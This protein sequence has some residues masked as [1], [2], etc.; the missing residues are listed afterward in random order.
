MARTPDYHRAALLASALLS[1][2]KDL[3][4]WRRGSIVSRV[5]VFESN[6]LEYLQSGLPFSA[7]TSNLSGEICGDGV[8]D[9]VADTVEQW[10]DRGVFVVRP[11]DHFRAETQVSE[12]APVL[13]AKGDQ[14]L[15]RSPIAAILNSR[16]PRRISPDHRWVQ[17]TLAEVKLVG[18]RDCAIAT[19]Y[20][21]GPY[22]LISVAA[23]RLACPVIVVCPEVLPF[24]VSNEKRTEFETTY[25]ELFASN[26]SLF[27]SPFSPGSMP[28][29]GVRLV[30]RDRV[31]AALA[32]YLLIAEIRAGGTMT[33]V[34]RAVH[35]GKERFTVFLPDAP[36]EG[37]S[38]NFRAREMLSSVKVEVLSDESVRK[39]RNEARADPRAM[40]AL[41]KKGELILSPVGEAGYL[42]HYTRSCPGPWPG[43]SLSDYYES[44]IDNG[45]G[46][47][48][49]AFDTLRR[50]LS[51]G[52]LRGSSTFVRGKTPVVSFTERTPYEI[53]ELV[54]WRRGLIRWSFE[55]YGIAIDRPTLVNLG[56]E[57]VAYGDEEV[58]KQMPTD[59]GYLF[60]LRA[61]RDN[62]WS[63]E[64]EWRTRGDL[65]L[66]DI[67]QAH[68]TVVV[69]SLE[70]ARLVQCEF[71][72]SVTLA[73]VSDEKSF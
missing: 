51:E 61:S 47:E 56:A 23:R 43:Q 72:Y 14:S 18:R 5:P 45:P 73:G 2:R 42:I 7:D 3:D 49:S 25:G 66:G 40:P 44:L 52:L 39:C 69:P 46:A 53:H 27:L 71:G 22:D 17:T 31:V 6:A 19:S 28:P 26:Q 48:H 50:M 16:K 59:R 13:F 65:K 54:R 58:F 24:M 63:G 35:E 57:P 60:Q 15:L 64:K 38:G 30:V 37:T 32:Q 41:S 55:P 21:S 1:S 4:Y 70:E 20:G 9:R 29:T 67:P 12:V 10:L 36:D 33:D 34:L 68:I 8:T 11:E 62:D